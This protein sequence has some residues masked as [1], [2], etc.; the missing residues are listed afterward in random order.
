MTKESGIG[1]IVPAPPAT[2]PKATGL[3][4]AEAAR[5][6]AARGRAPR[7]RSSRSY[8]SIV[9]ANVFTV[10]NLILALAGAA[11]L[12]F[13]EW[14]DALFL[15][16]LVSNTGIGIVQE[17]RAKRALDK[18]SALVAPQATAI[19]DGHART[20]PIDE[21]VVGDL[22]RVGPGDQVVADGTVEHAET[23]RLDESI[24]TGESEPV[25]RAAGDSVRS[26]SFAVE[27][28]G[29]YTVTAVGADSYA[30]RLTGEA[31]SF[32]HPRSPLERALN[33][34][35]FVLVARDGAAGP[36]AGLRALAPAC[37]AA[38]RRPH[39]GRRRR[40]ARPRRA[41]PA[42]EPHVRRGGLADG[43]PRRPR[44]AAERDRVAR[45]RRRGL[46][47][48]D[49]HADRAGA[50]CRRRRSA[51]RRC[52]TSSGASPPPPPSATPRSRRSRT[53]VQPSPERSPRKSR[54]RRGSASARSASTASATCSAPPSTSGS[55][56]SPTAPPGLPG[57]GDA[58]SPSA[59][60]TSSRSRLRGRS[61]SL[62]SPSACGRRRARPSSGSA[63]RASS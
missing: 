60:P 30:A 18:L 34:L 63:R 41:D 12:A 59:R 5:R 29:E 57:K 31:R 61:G 62:S 6:L 13:G 1:A 49:R 43:A 10:F 26:G 48:Q 21:L 40:H 38:H 47:R 46:P 44:P 14:Q 27:G 15:G 39:L 52:A 32:R 33:R 36:R 11:T 2:S 53:P 19:R 35:L 51:R 28:V 4:E 22:L 50:A 24:L 54:S 7:R 3:T 16:V 58:C 55:A 56:A 42:R 17:V 25:A 9:R 37:D 23:L 45:L 20:V 8:A